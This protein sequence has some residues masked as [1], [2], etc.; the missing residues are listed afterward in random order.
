MSDPADFPR[1]LVNVRPRPCEASQMVSIIRS[2]GAPANSLD[3]VPRITS[4]AGR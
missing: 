3:I 4:F 2:H 1:V